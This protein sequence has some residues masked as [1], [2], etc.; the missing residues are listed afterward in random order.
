M[1]AAAM[2]HGYVGG[3]IDIVPEEEIEDECEDLFSPDVNQPLLKDSDGEEDGE[4]DGKPA[5]SWELQLVL[6][7]SFMASGLMFGMPGMPIAYFAENTL[8]LT[9]EQESTTLSMNSFAQLFPF[10]IKPIYGLLS[11]TMPCFGERRRPYLMVGLLGCGISFCFLGHCVNTAQFTAVLLLNNIFKALV[12]TQAEALVIDFAIEKQLTVVEVGKILSLVWFCNS[13]GQ[14]LGAVLGGMALYALRSEMVFLLCAA[15]P[16]VC[17]VL[18]IM[19]GS[20]EPPITQHSDQSITATLVEYKTVIGS[21]LKDSSI[22][23]VVL[24]NVIFFSMPVLGLT[25]SGL[26]FYYFSDHL[27]IDSEALSFL[28]AITFAG[29]AG[30]I[31]LYEQALD[32]YKFSLRRAIEVLIPMLALIELFGLPLFF[33][34]TLGNQ[35]VSIIYVICF[36]LLAGMVQGP[37]LIAFFTMVAQCCPSQA[38]A[39]VMAVFTSIQNTALLTG[40]QITGALQLV[41]GVTTDNYDN[42]W[43]I[44]AICAAAVGSTLLWTFLLPHDFTEIQRNLEARTQKALNDLHNEQQL[45]DDKINNSS[46]DK[47]C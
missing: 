42:V 28:P 14:C 45:E 35:P 36:S 4:E 19:V 26:A 43:V 25:D 13:I 41:F 5:L 30:G 9:P 3:G 23:W 32:R 11:D 21:T 8:K 7:S 44:C 38:E 33:G 1:T 31:W 20:V 2:E 6:L 17:L 18:I 34:S 24:F 12:L 10:C 47:K 27:K 39:T 46:I 15:P 22:A 40:N 16:L 29:M 37:L